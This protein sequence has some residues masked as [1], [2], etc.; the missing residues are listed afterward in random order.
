MNDNIDVKVSSFYV[1]LNMLKNISSSSANSL[2]EGIKNINLGKCTFS[3]NGLFTNGQKIIGDMFGSGSSFGI[4]NFIEKMNN[5]KEKLCELDEKTALYFKYLNNYDEEFAAD[6]EEV[7]GIQ[8]EVTRKNVLSAMPDYY[9]KCIALL[10]SGY[11]KHVQ[12]DERGGILGTVYLPP[13]YNGNGE[14]AMIIAMNGFGNESAAT[15]ESNPL[16]ARYGLQM[17]ME[18]GYDPGA[19]VYVPRYTGGSWVADS[20]ELYN[21]IMEI[22]NR[23]NV[24]QDRKSVIGFSGGGLGVSGLLE[25]APN[26]FSAAVIVGDHVK[27]YQAILNSSTQ[28]IIFNNAS[29][30]A[31]NLAIK[32]Y[33][34]NKELS[35]NVT[36]YNISGFDHGSSINAIL[37]SDLIN[38]ITNIERGKTYV[39]SYESIDVDSGVLKDNSLFYGNGNSDS[40]YHN[41]SDVTVK[42]DNTANL[43]IN[44]NSNI[45]TGISDF[46]FDLKSGDNNIF[47]N[48]IN[49]FNNFFDKLSNNSSRNVQEY[50]GISKKMYDD[51][52]KYLQNSG[53][54]MNSDGVWVRGNCFINV[55]MSDGLMKVEIDIN[56]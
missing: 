1:A 25:V 50:F 17:L 41:L 15:R 42:T 26:E 39:T 35:D 47:N 16:T 49:N 53:F 12:R 46:E 32:H 9:D 45:K 3:D 31:D 48:M 33:E 14:S 20:N 23:Y 7:I 2:A 18:S 6:F 38:D 51:Y 30:D 22:A 27:N 40:W 56:K 5:F 52:I 24:D 55:D 29:D 4:S 8:D 19:V 36:M 37:C 54:S 28:V 34:E 44:N 11:T 43:Q 10:S 13:N 21:R